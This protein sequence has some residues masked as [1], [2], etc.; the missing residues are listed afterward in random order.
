[1]QEIM[2]RYLQGR[3]F[4]KNPVKSFCHP[5]LQLVSPQSTVLQ[6]KHAVVKFS[7]DKPF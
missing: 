2:P 6:I 3:C 1:M 4:D 5:L 7:S